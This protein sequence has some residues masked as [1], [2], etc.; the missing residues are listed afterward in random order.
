[1]ETYDIGDYVPWIKSAFTTING[2]V[3]F[4]SCV[5]ADGW[6]GGQ[7]YETIVNYCDAIMPMLYLG[8]YNKSSTDLTNFCK[9]WFEKLKGKFW[10]CLETYNSDEDTTPKTESRLRAEI[11][12]VSG[13]IKGIGLFRYGLSNFSGL[14]ST[15]TDT[16]T[17]TTTNTTPTTSSTEC[18]DNAL[19][20]G[21]QGDNVKTLQTWLNN[22]GFGTLAVDGDFG[23]LTETAVKKFQT[24]VGISSDGKGKNGNLHSK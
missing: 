7:L 2:E 15:S 14:T 20:N 13:Y 18:D 5:K 24:T 1:M 11:K 16:T 6:D 22:N 4:I 21:C 10:A 3:Q 23:D 17:N 9:T 19:K 12:A 8:D